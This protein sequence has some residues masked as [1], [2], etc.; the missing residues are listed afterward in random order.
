MIGDRT[1]LFRDVAILDVSREDRSVVDGTA[2]L[3][4]GF[5][6]AG[7]YYLCSSSVN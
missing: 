3:G 2:L 6:S 1:G 7:W 4:V 5:D